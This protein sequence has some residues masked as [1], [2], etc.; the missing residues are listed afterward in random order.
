[1]Y[2]TVHILRIPATGVP[3][4]PGIPQSP[5]IVWNSWESVAVSIQLQTEESDMSQNTPSPANVAANRK[6]RVWRE[7][8]DAE[9][10][11]RDALDARVAASK[12]HPTVYTSGT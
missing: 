4:S 9:Q 11:R 10:A 12:V 7:E 3:R 5:G 6:K 1:M 8:R 2:R